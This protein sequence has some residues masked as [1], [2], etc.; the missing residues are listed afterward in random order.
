MWWTGDGGQRQAVSRLRPRLPRRDGQGVRQGRPHHPQPHRASLLTGLP[1]RTE[2]DEAYIKEMLAWPMGRELA[3]PYT[4]ASPASSLRNG[5]GGIMY[6]DSHTGDFGSYYTE[7]LPP[8]STHRRRVRLHLCGRLMQGKTLGE[9]LALAADYTVECIRATLNDPEAVS[10]GVE[11]EKAI[12]Y[13]V[14]RMK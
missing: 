10:Y 2:Y 5:T 11:F 8:P 3:C 12:P 4:A 13:L 14:D 7:Y 9:S 1:Y 6:Y